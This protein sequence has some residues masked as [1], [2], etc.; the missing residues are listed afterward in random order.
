[1]WNW[2]RKVSS[3]CSLSL[4]PHEAG[5]D[6][7][8]GQ[9]V[10]DGLVHQGGG[11]RRVD[12]AGQG[13]QHR[14]VAHLGPHRRHLCLDDRGVG[15]RR[16]AVADVVEE[17]L[18]EVPAPLGVDH[19]G[20]ELHAVDAAVGVVEGGHRGVGAGGRGHEPVGHRGDG[21]AVAHPHL[22]LGRPVD[23]ERGGAGEGQ[24]GPAV[25]APTGAGHLAAQLLGQQLGAVADAQD[26]DARV[27]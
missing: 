6:V 4:G 8:A 21:V 3:T 13:A 23:E 5:V 11:H 20:V 17:A 18:Q 14:R 12:A 2:R 9:L 19:L 15:P 25:L 22:G 1:M 10:A 26:G 7:H 27:S 24:R 16:R